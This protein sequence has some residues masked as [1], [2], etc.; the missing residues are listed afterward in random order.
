MYAKQLAAILVVFNIFVN[1]VD[2]KPTTQKPLLADIPKAVNNFQKRLK[3]TEE[4]IQTKK[5][6]VA[7]WGGCDEECQKQTEVYNAMKE[8]QATKRPVFTL[9]IEDL[10]TKHDYFGDDDTDW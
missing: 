4:E 6:T 1:F 8:L 10:L 9:S 3:A 2:S 5:K 7:I